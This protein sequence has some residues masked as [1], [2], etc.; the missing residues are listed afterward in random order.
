MPSMPKNDLNRA[1]LL[2]AIWILTVLG[3]LLAGLAFTLFPL[4]PFD[5]AKSIADLIARDRDLESFTPAHHEKLKGLIWLGLGF[6]VSGSTLAWEKTKG[7]EIVEKGVSFLCRVKSRISQ[8]IR[9]MI[10]SLRFLLQERWHLALLGVILGI[11]IVNDAQF[12]NRSMRYDEAYTF[13][14]FASRPLIRIIS[15]YSLPNNHIFHSI[16]VHFAYKI[17]GGQPWVVRLPAFI[18]GMLLIPA[19]YLTGRTFFSANVALFGSGLIAFFSALVDSAVNARGYTI[20]CLITLLL[21]AFGEYVKSHKNRTAWGI[22]ILLAAVGLYTV[23]TMI[24]PLGS[25]GLWLFAS[26]FFCKTSPEYGGFS[27]IKYL[28]LFSA[29]TLFLTLLFYAPV[30]IVSGYQSAVSNSFVRPL[31]PSEF[32]FKLA[33]RLKET[34]ESWNSGVPAAMMVMLIVGF[35]LSFLFY[36]RLSKRQVWFPILMILFSSAVV[37]I[38]RVAPFDR[39][40]LFA[41]PIFLIWAAAGLWYVFEVSFGRM[42]KKFRFLNL[43]SKAGMLV[44]CCFILAFFGNAY[45]FKIMDRNAKYEEI[46]LFLQGYVSPADVVVTTFPDDAPLRYYYQLYQQH[47][48]DVFS[49]RDDPE[50]ILVIANPGSGQTI[51]SVLRQ[52]KYPLELSG[53]KPA[54]QLFESD[55]LCVFELERQP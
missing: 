48:D 29:L 35:C 6:L 53:L 15:D 38:R 3:L 20:I 8:D 22:M 7:I 17:F 28:I 18:A 51:D 16:L 25:V 54:L 46:A 1:K 44:L 43:T 41:V 21:L 10:F 27:F 23:P 13:N 19:G 40:W 37:L 4:L 24:F 2:R 49:F 45:Q 36:R 42:T 33:G 47:P 32:W 55:G 34:W 11:A 9:A 52:Q 31:N 12:L 26:W 50:R 30:F 14:I 39:M 5:A